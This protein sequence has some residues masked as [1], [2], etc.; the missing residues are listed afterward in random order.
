[1]RFLLAISN[2]SIGAARMLQGLSD[3]WEAFEAGLDRFGG[4]LV[5]LYA[6]AGRYDAIAVVDF[7]SA[8]GVLAFTLAAT[9]QGQRVEPMLVFDRDEATKAEEIA[10]TASARHADD[11]AQAVDALG[12]SE[13][14]KAKS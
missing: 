13:A 10:R 12:D 3:G 5:T 1:V 8:S 2:D 4:A 11:L 7:E 14:A 9:S 6:V